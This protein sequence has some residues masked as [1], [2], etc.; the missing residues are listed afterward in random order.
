MK[1]IFILIVI[2]IMMTGCSNKIE[3]FYLT[4][5]YYNGGEFIKVE[6]TDVNNLNNESYVLFTYN[7]FCNM[8]IPCENIFKE[9]ME[10][11]KINFLSIPYENFKDTELHKTVEFAPSIIIVNNGKIIKY[12]DAEKDEDLKRYQDLNE[13]ESWISKYIYLEKNN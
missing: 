5:K 7:N 2:A 11:Y 4:D 8:Q 13:F 3:K 9:F 6:S 10:K 1:K 12:L